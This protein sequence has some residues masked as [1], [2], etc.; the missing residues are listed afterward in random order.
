MHV[1]DY[2][3]IRGTTIADLNREMREHLAYGWQPLGPAQPKSGDGWNQTVVKYAPVSEQDEPIVL[4]LD[5][6]QALASL[7]EPDALVMMRLD[8][9]EVK[10]ALHAIRHILVKSNRLVG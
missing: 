4:E 10:S 7:L 1:I 8:D 6:A 3:V 9:V 5:H 2:R